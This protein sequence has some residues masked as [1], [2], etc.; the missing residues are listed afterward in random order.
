MQDVLRA[1]MIAADMAAYA[2]QLRIGEAMELSE[3]G[4]VLTGDREQCGAEMRSRGVASWGIPD[5][6]CAHTDG[7][8]A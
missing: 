1:C 3:G 2:K 5:C 4:S 6:Q 8:E 7:L